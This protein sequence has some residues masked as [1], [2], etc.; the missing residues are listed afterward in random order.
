MNK[1]T[2]VFSVLALLFS[3]FATKAT[4][5]EVSGL[6]VSPAVT[7]VQEEDLGST[8]GIKLVNN[9]SSEVTIKPTIKTVERGED[10]KVINIEDGSQDSILDFSTE[11]ITLTP[12]GEYT[13]PV[14]IKIEEY[15]GSGY[16][17]VAFT[18]LS[19][20]GDQ[21]VDITKEL[22]SVFL[23]QNIKGNLGI[24]SSIEVNSKPILISPELTISGQVIN[25]GTKFFNPSGTMRLY[26]GKTLINE[27]QITTQ[28]EGLLFASQQK[29]F[30]SVIQLPGNILERLGEYTL[31]TRI[32]PSPF[33]Q[34]HVTKV[35]FYHVPVE[36]FAII[37][38]ILLIT[39]LSVSL[40]KGKKR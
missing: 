34:T 14:R 18:L 27:Q 11:I 24:D 22:Y 10:G 20:K 28:I 1:L 5:Q 2:I 16:P 15:S 39:I 30:S 3:S 9:S 38:P 17:A 23:I 40:L 33:D 7:I 13:L 25:S 21:T 31:E 36:Y 37:I 4:A 8:V 12:S 32:Q 26:K 35:H 29:P 19:E 6:L